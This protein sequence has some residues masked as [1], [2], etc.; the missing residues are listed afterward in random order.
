MV[1]LA[2]LIFLAPAFAQTSDEDVPSFE[3]WVPYKKK[4]FSKYFSGQPVV[5]WALAK[6]LL[7]EAQVEEE[8]KKSLG[9][10]TPSPLLLE[11]PTLPQETPMLPQGALLVPTATEGGR[12]EVM[13]TQIL[14]TRHQ[15]LVPIITAI[16]YIKS[17]NFRF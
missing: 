16:D 17:V 13:W 10:L 4:V 15:V 7:Q 6:F 12:R 11:T 14:I 2:I 1:G 9:M 8:I 5:R 3:R